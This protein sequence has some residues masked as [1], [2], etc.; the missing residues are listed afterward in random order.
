M[1]VSCNAYAEP[2]D[3]IFLWSLENSQGMINLQNWSSWHMLSYSVTDYGYGTLSCWGQNSI[4]VQEYP[5]QLKLL[6][7]SIPEAPHSCVL[8]N[9]SS[10]FFSIECEPGYNGSLYQ[11]FHLEVY[12]SKK[13]NL[14][15][16]LTEVT[17]PSFK[18]DALSPGKTYV[19]LIYSSNAKGNSNSVALVATTLLSKEQRTSEEFH[20]NIKIAS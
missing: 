5:C 18:V 9:L 14:R 4:G 1:N 8:S 13:E 20:L 19:L 12:C 15:H 16:N 2:E 7:A 11:E 10:H 17:T 6:A 3:L